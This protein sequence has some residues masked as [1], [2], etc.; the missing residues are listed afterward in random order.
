MINSCHLLSANYV[1]DTSLGAFPVSSLFAMINAGIRR[2]CF[3]L[4][5]SL[6]CGGGG[7]LCYL[8]TVYHL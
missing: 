7:S 3:M 1:L 4:T 6:P 8:Q 2:Q 5:K